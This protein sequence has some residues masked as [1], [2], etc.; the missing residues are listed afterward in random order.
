MII[1]RIIVLRIRKTTG[2]V[3]M[4]VWFHTTIIALLLVVARDAMFVTI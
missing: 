1:T 3:G 4:P 2:G